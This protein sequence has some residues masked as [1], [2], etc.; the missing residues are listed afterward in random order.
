MKRFHSDKTADFSSLKR[1]LNGIEAE[2][3]KSS[4]YTPQ[5]NGVAERK[6]QTLLA[7]VRAMLSQAGMYHRFGG[8]EI[9]NA[10]YVHKRTCTLVLNMKTPMNMLLNKM[11]ENSQI[12]GFGCT[13]YIHMHK[14]TRKNKLD[15]RAGQGVYLSS[16]RGIYRICTILKKEVIN[17]KQAVFDEESFLLPKSKIKESIYFNEEISDKKLTNSENS[18]NEKRLWHVPANPES[19]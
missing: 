10:A 17:T 15:E 14:E 16:H 7:K 6:I 18:A 9:I 4:A 3:T 2:Q 12:K 19:W 8:E 11:S 5:L 1:E 13:S